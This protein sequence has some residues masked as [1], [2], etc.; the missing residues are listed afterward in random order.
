M[1]PYM[2]SLCT[3]VGILPGIYTPVHT[4]GR[5]TLPYTPRTYP[6]HVPLETPNGCVYVQFWQKE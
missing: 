2:P 5:Y 3:L 4:P 6:A 1:P